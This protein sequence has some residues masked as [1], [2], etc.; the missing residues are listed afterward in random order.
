MLNSADIGTF[1]VIENTNF[2]LCQEPIDTIPS[3][4][5]TQSL[6][7][8]QNNH[9]NTTMEPKSNTTKF[10]NHKDFMDVASKVSNACKRSHRYANIVFGLMLNMLD[11][12]KVHEATN[13]G[14]FE[15]SLEKSFPQLICKY[16]AAF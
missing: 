8:L 9:S 15:E 10:L 3:P 6:S 2:T 4:E 12:S 7:N 1:Q 5:V 13:I 11:I 16:T 14:N